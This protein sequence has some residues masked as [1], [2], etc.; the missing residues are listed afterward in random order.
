MKVVD[1]L[2]VNMCLLC[3]I[4]VWWFWSKCWF[5]HHLSYLR[6]NNYANRASDL[7]EVIPPFGKSTSISN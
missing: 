3:K 4:L 2:I 6:N 5:E 1:I 7:A